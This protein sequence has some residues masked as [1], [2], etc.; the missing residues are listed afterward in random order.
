MKKALKTLLLVAMIVLLVVACVA[1]QDTPQETKITVKFVNG[2]EVVKTVDL[3]DGAKLSAS[4]IPAD[5]TAPQGK[6]FAGWFNG[7]VK[8]ELGKTEI[9]ADVTFEAKFT[10]KAEPQ[11]EKVTVL[12]KNGEQTVKSVELDKGAMLKAADLPENPQAPQGKAFDGW[13]NGTAK[14]QIGLEI[15]ADA[16]FEAKFVSNSWKVTFKNG[17]QVVSETFVLKEGSGKVAAADIPADPQAPQD[18]VFM[19]WYNADAVAAKDAEVKSDA[20][21]VAAFAGESDYVGGWYNDQE[22]LYLSIEADNSLI[23]NVNQSKK[24]VTGVFDAADGAFKFEFG[25]LASKVTV[26]VINVHGL[27]KLSYSAWDSIEEDF[28]TSTYA[29]AKAE[30]VSA[31]YVATK[32]D[33]F[34]LKHGILISAGSTFVYG[35]LNKDGEDLSV[36][37]YSSYSADLSEQ[38]IVVDAKGAWA[39][40]DKLYFNE[41]NSTSYSYKTADEKWEYLYLHKIDDDTTHIV[42]RNKDDQDKYVTVEGALAEGEIVAIKFADNS[43]IEAKV[44][45]TSL[46]ASGAEAGTYTGAAGQIVLDGFGNA[47]VGDATDQTYVVYG[48]FVVI[49]ESAIILDKDAHTASLAPAIQGGIGGEFEQNGNNKYVATFFE[50]GLVVLDYNNG[51]YVYNGVYTVSSGKIVVAGVNGN[52]NGTYAVEE[53]GN[54]LVEQGGSKLYL[55][56]GVEFQ[57]HIDDFKGM[58]KD[59]SDN[60]VVINVVSSK[61]TYKGTE[62]AFTKNY[63]GTV[64]KFT[65][66]DGG[67]KT[68]NIDR[69]FTVTIQ[70]EQL[71]IVHDQCTGFDDD[72]GAEL[73]ALTELFDRAQATLDGWQGIY[74]NSTNELVINGDGTGTYNKTAIS[75]TIESDSLKFELS[76]TSHTATKTSDGFNVHFYDGGDIDYTLLF[77]KTGDIGGG[78]EE[79]VAHACVGTWTGE[80]YGNHNIVVNADGTLTFDG[81]T[82]NWTAKN[83]NEI[84]FTAGDNEFTLN[85]STKTVNYVYDG[86]D[87][88]SWDNVTFTPASGGLKNN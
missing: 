58:W 13:Y 23:S 38:A 76:G 80:K 47:Q 10:D 53:N 2:S 61:I 36:L 22:K 69:E 43:R 68:P 9:K 19:G 17:E 60:E 48:E 45:G 65:G 79:P 4:D 71:K 59:T 82:Y 27:L 88:Y 56:Q 39:I 55:K 85:S 11:P 63:N 30:E 83:D 35:R 37:M 50:C 66:K 40:G 18:K 74:A 1:C 62:F 73:A 54:V 26:S 5:P 14:A 28:V 84:T 32:T 46:L 75:Y 67:S 49:G 78:S 72:G 3:K 64:L 41:Q 52:I 77:K 51:A 29:L 70:G 8:F 87:E 86:Y 15:N 33:Y 44:K 21:F 25:S 20:E 24:T 34:E 12:F 31:K 16:T 57:D 6:E 42:W 81:T 7:E